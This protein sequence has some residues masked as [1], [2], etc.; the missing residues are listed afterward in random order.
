MMKTAELTV[1]D[2][3]RLQSEIEALLQVK[4][5][6]K[7]KF[8]LTTLL[9]K[10]KAQTQAGHN[11]LQ[12]LF[13]ENGKKAPNG[14]LYL[15]EYTDTKEKTEEFRQFEEINAQ[16]VTVEYEEIDKAVEEMETAYP[17]QV[18]LKLM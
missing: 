4:T 7:L 8:Q 12:D 6:V 10:L 11:M 18:L 13:R 14:T 5:K 17:I 15:Q 2:A 3:I 16:K 1:E 9:L